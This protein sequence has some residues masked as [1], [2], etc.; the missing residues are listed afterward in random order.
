MVVDVTHKVVDDDDDDDVFEVEIVDE[1]LSVQDIN[2]DCVSARVSAR[3]VDVNA[4]ID[5]FVF[6]FAGLSPCTLR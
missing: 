6:L 3:D 5:G 4:V 1:I 2:D